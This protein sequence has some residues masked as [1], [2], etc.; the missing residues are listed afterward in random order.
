VITAAVL[1][2][3]KVVSIALVIGFALLTAGAAQLVIPLPYTPVP[4]TGQTFVVLLAGVAL[5]SNLG[6]ASMALYVA[7][8]AIGLPF[9]AEGSSGIE[10]VRGATGG[11]LVGFVVAAWVMGWLAERRQDRAMATAIPL[12]LLGSVTIHLFGVP[13]LA[14]TLGVSGTE[15]IELGSVPFIVGDLVKVV[16]AG[17]VLPATWRLVRT[18]RNP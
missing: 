4:I 18:L 6:A 12:F 15:A 2:R 17:T 8:G 1:P 13:W 16:V 3:S 11:Y 7:L 14:H 9:Y 5:G 10:V